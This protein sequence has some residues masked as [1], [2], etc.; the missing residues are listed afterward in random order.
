MHFGQQNVKI[1]GALCWWEN[2]NK[3]HGGRRGVLKQRHCQLQNCLI[4]WF[5]VPKIFLKR[6]ELGAFHTYAILILRNLTSA[7][8]ADKLNFSTIFSQL[9]AF[10]FLSLKSLLLR[11]LTHYYRATSSINSLLVNITLFNTSHVNNK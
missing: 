8:A 6:Q 9:L 5:W 2:R 7:S 10:L 3:Q 11:W 1:T 4:H